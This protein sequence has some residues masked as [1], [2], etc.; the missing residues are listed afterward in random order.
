MKPAK[1]ARGWAIKHWSGG[2]YIETVSERRRDAVETFKHLYGAE[3]WKEPSPRIVH[4][5]VK[6]VVLEVISPKQAGSPEGGG[7]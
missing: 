1:A 3:T 4:R 5:A 6:V 2:L 7:G